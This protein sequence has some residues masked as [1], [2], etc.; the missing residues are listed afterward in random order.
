MFHV[1][2]LGIGMFKYGLHTNAS[3]YAA[4]GSSL[5]NIFIIIMIIMIGSRVCRMC[6]VYLHVIYAILAVANK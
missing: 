5:I 2:I 6:F 4:N 3:Y 1:A